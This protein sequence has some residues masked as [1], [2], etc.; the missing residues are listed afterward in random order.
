MV[1]RFS[2]EELA[3]LKSGLMQ[4]MLDAHQGAELLQMFLVGRGYGVNREAAID[5]VTRLEASGCSFDILQKELE[6]L[7]LVM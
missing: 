5:S 4:S 1:E 6:G 7:A 3:A 2:T